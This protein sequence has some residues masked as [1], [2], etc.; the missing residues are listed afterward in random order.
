MTIALIFAGLPPAVSDLLDIGGLAQISDHTLARY[1]LS[2]K[3]LNMAWAVLNPEDTP[4]LVEYGNATEA[5]VPTV[6]PLPPEL[7]TAQ[8]STLLS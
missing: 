7:P 6:G 8:L 4:I 3:F 5:R 1:S 2:L